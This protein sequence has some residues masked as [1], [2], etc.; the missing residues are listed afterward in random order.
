MDMDLD[1]IQRLLEIVA[2]SGLAEVK[3][4]EEGFK[5]TVRATQRPVAAP[6]AAPVVM[7][8]QTPAAAPAPPSA[9]AAEAPGGATGGAAAEP[10]SGAGESLVLAPIVGTFY[11]APSPESDPFVAVGEPEPAEAVAAQVHADAGVPPRA[12]LAHALDADGVVEERAQL[13]GPGAGAGHVG[14]QVAG[15][16][17]RRRDDGLVGRERPL[18][19]VAGGPT[20]ALE[21]GVGHRLAAA[22][23]ASRHGDPKPQR[24][25]QP[26]RGDRRAGVE[27][28]DVAGGEERDGH[29]R[30]DGPE[31]PR[32]DGGR[33][34]CA[35]LQP[36]PTRAPAAT[37]SARRR[38]PVRAGYWLRT[39]SCCRAATR[40]RRPLAGRA[41][42]RRE[43]TTGSRR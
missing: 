26:Q 14:A 12:Q 30:G 13:L 22:H 31:A 38:A 7:S 32:P 28:V 20:G 27:L 18:V 17:P 41:R 25:Q 37:A 39:S 36:T 16:A 6:P 42:L 35:A 19:R 3:V 8:A 10:G 29:H 2:E 34:T 21:A 24:F 23:G 1:K 4:E 33:R 11:A 15:A 5:L 40:W 9:A 43:P